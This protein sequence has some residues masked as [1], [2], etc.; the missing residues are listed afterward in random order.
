MK[1]TSVQST[2]KNSIIKMNICQAIEI[3]ERAIEDPRNG[4]PEEIFLF[5]TR[6]VPMVNI[7]LLIKDEKN[8]TLLAWRDDPYSGRGWHVPGGIIRYKEKLIERVEKVAQIEIGTP[9]K[10]DPEP[11][12]IN[13]II[14][15]QRTRGHFISFLYRGFVPSSFVPA[16]TGLKENDNGYLQ[17]HSFCPED[18]IRVHEI[19]RKFI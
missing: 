6:V 7:D 18:L 2:G 12:A 1:K 17:W 13:E 4:L 15:S 14:L 9:V 8:R 16:N 10:F 5:I 11:V 3:L 19:Y